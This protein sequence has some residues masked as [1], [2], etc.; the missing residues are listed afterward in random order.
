MR[1]F[2]FAPCL[3]LLLIF[4]TAI[5][6]TACNRLQSSAEELLYE[7]IT[8]SRQNHIY[9]RPALRTARLAT[10]KEGERIQVLQ[11][12]RN[13]WLKIRTATGQ[14]GWIETRDVLKRDYFDQWQELAPQIQQQP[15]QMQGDTLAEAYLRLQPGR[16]TVKVYKLSENQ[17][18]DIFAIAYTERPLPAGAA[19]LPPPPPVKK[20]VDNKAPLPGKKGKKSRRSA[21]NGKKYDTWYLVRTNQGAAGWMFAGLVSLRIPEE[22]ARFAESKLITTWRNIGQ[23]KD[24]EGNDRPSYLLLERE[25]NA[26]RDFDRLRVL[27]WNRG[28]KRYDTTARISDVVGFLPLD[29]QPPRAETTTYRFKIQH[30]NPDNPRQIFT[31]EYESNGMLL[32]KLGRAVEDF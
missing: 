24:L 7:T 32:K 31:D 11:E 5:I 27:S 13:R 2:R 30:F 14:V 9:E 29:F 21:D 12:P 16:D 6:G 1:R 17:P 18:V 8:T 28:R 26:P 25:E 19:A 4:S 22:V 20:P 10:I 15:L 23:V 3:L